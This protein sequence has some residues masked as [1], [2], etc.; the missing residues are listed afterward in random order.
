MK[1]NWFF[2]K[3]FFTFICITYVYV[4]LH[5]WTARSGRKLNQLSHPGAPRIGS[6]KRSMKVTNFY[7]DWQEKE[8]ED[9]LITSIRNEARD[10]TT[11][12]SD[13]KE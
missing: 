9:K 1:Q 3:I 13:E 2:K 8:R 7:H 6:F 12:P 4:Y 5:K 11:D 10:I